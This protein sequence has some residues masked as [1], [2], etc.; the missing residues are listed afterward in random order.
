MGEVINLRQARKKKARAAK[1]EQAAEN[2]SRY[3]VPKTER[4]KRAAEDELQRR[5][6]ESLKRDKPDEHE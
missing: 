2:R 3:G 1:E 5:R 4:E 6:L